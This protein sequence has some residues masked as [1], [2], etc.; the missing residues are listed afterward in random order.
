MTMGQRK[1][2]T[3]SLCR[4]YLGFQCKA[5][6]SRLSLT[7][8]QRRWMRGR[9]TTEQGREIGVAL[10]TGGLVRGNSVRTVWD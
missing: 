3:K 6:I 9:F 2:C 5:G 8:E 4:K 1:S 10:P 7:W